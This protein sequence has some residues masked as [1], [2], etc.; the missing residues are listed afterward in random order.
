MRY[1]MLVVA[2]AWMAMGITVAYAPDA[3]SSFLS[4]ETFGPWVRMMGL[5]PLVVGA[6]L[7]IAAHR[8]HLR[9]YLRIVGTIAVL[10]GLFLLIAPP[11]LSMGITEWYL[12]QPL[13][14]LRISG[15]IS[16]AVALPIAAVAVISLFE[17]NVI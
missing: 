8:F 12:G 10:K 13:W 17:E 4:I 5:I 16:I 15:F 7:L 11:S 2:A 9:I 3:V 6:V 1:L 14:F